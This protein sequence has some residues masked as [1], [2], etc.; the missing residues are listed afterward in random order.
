MRS[1]GVLNR[2]AEV[3]IHAFN[4]RGLVLTADAGSSATFRWPYADAFMV[5]T[6]ICRSH[7]YA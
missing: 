7:S 5:A 4:V 2:S 3:K 6:M 1:I